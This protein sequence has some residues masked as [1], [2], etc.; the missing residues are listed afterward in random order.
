MPSPHLT[1]GGVD[2]TISFGPDG[3]SEG[4]TEAWPV[5]GATATVYY[6]CAWTDRYTL[7]QALIGSSSYVDNVLIRVPPHKYPPSPNL[8][9]G[10]LGTI[11]P[12]GIGVLQTSQGGLPAGWMTAQYAIVPAT[13]I[14]PHFDTGAS[15]DPPTDPSGQP[16]TTTRFRISGDVF[17]PPNR[18]YKYVQRTGDPNYPQGTSA[19][20]PVADSLLG[21]IRPQ[22]EISMTRHRVPVEAFSI[23]S[24]VG[25]IGKVNDNNVQF[26]NH[27]FEEGYLLFSGFNSTATV[28]TIGSLTFE[29]EY[30]LLGRFDYSWNTI[31]APDTNWYLINTKADETGQYPFDYA[32]F[33]NIP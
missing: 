17:T 2:C 13:Y 23:E 33:A 4:V 8:V 28:D 22:I 5:D 29:V 3:T 7:A 32:D 14:V 10:S 18:T 24:I 27:I 6:R 30:G 12:Y 11:Q 21:I 20:I 26:G 16:W 15:S 25:F 19:G 31:M 1:I 9:C